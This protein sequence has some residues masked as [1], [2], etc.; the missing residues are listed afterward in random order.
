MSEKKPGFNSE[1]KISVLC[2][3]MHHYFAK[4]FGYFCLSSLSSNVALYQMVIQLLSID[5]LLLSD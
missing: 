4:M 2:R 1:L 5:Q 3:T